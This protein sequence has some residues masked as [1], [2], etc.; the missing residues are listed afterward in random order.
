M[1]VAMQDMDRIMVGAQH[2]ANHHVDTIVHY[3]TF[4]LLSQQ[5][6]I[7]FQFEGNAKGIGRPLRPQHTKHLGD[8]CQCQ[9][10]I[11]GLIVLV[12]FRIL[13]IVAVVVIM[14]IIGG[15]YLVL[16]LLWTIKIR[17]GSRQ[18]EHAQ[19]FGRT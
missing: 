19:G 3:G 6:S 13:V 12:L 7:R 15:L 10:Q 5:G 2:I 11:L 16:C 14:V 1:I 17:N 4:C 8:G 9:Y 18:V